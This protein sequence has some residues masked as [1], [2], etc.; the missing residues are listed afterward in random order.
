ME[1]CEDLD[2]VD[3]VVGDLGDRSIV[4]VVAAVVVLLWAPP[5][6]VGVVEMAPST[7]VLV[8]GDGSRIRTKSSTSK[9][10]Q[11]GGGSE[12]GRH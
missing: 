10:G 6:V 2:A 9:R 11:G 3:D 8:V 12:E 4:A 5:L 1:A 7:R